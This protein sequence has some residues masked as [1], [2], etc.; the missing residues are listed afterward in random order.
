MSLP[1]DQGTILAYI[2]SSSAVGSVLTGFFMRL[3]NKWF[4]KT[5]G[6]ASKEYVDKEIARAFSRMDKI[7]EE[8]KLKADEKTLEEMKRMMEKMDSRVFDIWKSMPTQ[9]TRGK[10]TS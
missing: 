1:P 8:I 4:D 3:F 5:D 6:A 2:A 7:D 9:K 10:T